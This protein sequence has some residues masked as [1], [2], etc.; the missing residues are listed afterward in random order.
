MY[1]SVACLQMHYGV[2]VL[3]LQHRHVLRR[4]HMKC[5]LADT[6][7]VS[8]I[9]YIFLAFDVSV[10]LHACARLTWLFLEVSTHAH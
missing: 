7:K 6:S 1:T 4:F 3:H 10:T 2:R 9:P 5:L 8:H